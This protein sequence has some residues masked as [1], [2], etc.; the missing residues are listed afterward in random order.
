M[1]TIHRVDGLRPKGGLGTNNGSASLGE[2]GKQIQDQVGDQLI[3]SR[4]SGEEEDEAVAVA[5]KHRLYDSI[6]RCHL[7]RP[8]VDPYKA[9]GEVLDGADLGSQFA[10]FSA[11]K[12]FQE[13]ATRGGRPIS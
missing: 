8:E 3:L 1:Q 9:S 5:G 11:G 2:A 10:M 4:L 6:R 7:I 13:A 12:L